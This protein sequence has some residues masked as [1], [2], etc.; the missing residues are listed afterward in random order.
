MTADDAS[1][2]PVSFA[3]HDISDYWDSE[4]KGGKFGSGLF[5]TGSRS[6]PRLYEFIGDPDACD[7]RTFRK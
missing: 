7:I 5:V 4:V 3:F 1:D 6:A 2:W